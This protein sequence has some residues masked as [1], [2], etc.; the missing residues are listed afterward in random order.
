MLSSRWQVVVAPSAAAVLSLAVDR[1]ELLVQAEPDL[2]Q[3]RCVFVSNS[4]AAY[5]VHFFPNIVRQGVTYLRRRIR[6]HWTWPNQAIR[7][8]LE[9]IVL[10]VDGEGRVEELEDTVECRYVAGTGT[11]FLPL[12]SPKCKVACFRTRQ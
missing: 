6:S 2:R 7:Q 4:L 5:D 11:M 8:E 9:Y 3:H 1:L 10:V 12:V